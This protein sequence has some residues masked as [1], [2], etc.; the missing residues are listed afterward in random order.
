M[1]R[2]ILVSVSFFV[3]GKVQTNSFNTKAKDPQA[4]FDKV[5]ADA[6]AFAALRKGHVAITRKIDRLYVNYL[7][8]KCN[9]IDRTYLIKNWNL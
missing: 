4:F 3:K 2:N 9:A 5:I 7:D 6:N 8:I 1:N